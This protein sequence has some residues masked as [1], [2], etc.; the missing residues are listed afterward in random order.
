M[1]TIVLESAYSEKTSAREPNFSF[2]LMQ[3]MRMLSV[4]Q[5]QLARNI[6]VKP[7]TIQYL[8]TSNSTRSKFASDIADALG[9]NMEWL[10]TG[11]GP[12]MIEAPALDT[13]MK[14]PLISWSSIYGWLDGKKDDLSNSDYITTRYSFDPNSFSLKMNDSS[15]T[16]R[17]D[18]G[19][20]L[21]IE[22]SENFH[23]NDFVLVASKFS[24]TPILRQII[25]KGDK[26][27]LMPLNTS[28]YKEIMLEPDDRIIGILRQTINDFLQRK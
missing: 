19:T 28:L 4:S 18:I 14:V 25:K 7:Q 24:S 13:I 10:L 17:F 21:V 12:M 6:G 27:F 20:I 3:A 9:I 22:P 5:S 26:Q 11:R 16:P 23:E 8:C 1:T 2:R 15:M